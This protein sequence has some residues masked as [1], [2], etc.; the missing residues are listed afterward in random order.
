MGQS[1]ARLPAPR[2]RDAAE[3]RLYGK[4]SGWS[5]GKVSGMPAITSDRVTLSAERH[6]DPS[7]RVR[8][9]PRYV[10]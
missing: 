8:Q 3:N 6:H 4:N 2:L 1:H 5:S 7:G 10:T 9:R